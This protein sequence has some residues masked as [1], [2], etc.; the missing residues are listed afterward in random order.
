MDWH[1]RRERPYTGKNS[2]KW[3]TGGA[4]IK[5]RPGIPGRLQII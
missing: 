2:R 3:K 4:I 5:K 1:R